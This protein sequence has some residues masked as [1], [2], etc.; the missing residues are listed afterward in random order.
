MA[1][2]KNRFKAALAVGLTLALF[3]AAFALLASPAAVADTGPIKPLQ[4]T[5]RAL[6]A[7]QQQAQRLALASPSVQRYAEGARA[8]V[9]GTIDGKLASSIL[10]RQQ[11]KGLFECVVDG[12]TTI[13][14]GNTTY[15][16][17]QLQ[18][19]W[20]V[21]VKGSVTGPGSSG[22]CLVAADEVK[23]QQGG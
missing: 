22:S 5:E 20:R 17:A 8:E 13:R 11:G 19:G 18:Q 23:V 21:H 12:K 3:V 6:T 9:E 7:Q 15:T 10:V 14:K 16:F 1:E 2:Q 4:Q